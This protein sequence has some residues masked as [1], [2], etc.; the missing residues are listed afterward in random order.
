MI[1]FPH[2]KI[3]LGLNVTRRR[4]DGFHDIETVLY[5]VNWCDALEVIESSGG[6]PFTLDITGLPVSGAT[7]DNIIYKAWQKMSV[8]AKLPRMQVHLRKQ[9][10]MGAGLG[11][12]S[13]D[14]AFFL[15]LLNEKFELGLSDERLGAIAASLGSDC[16]FFLQAKP[17]LATGRGE[18][19]SPVKVDLGGYYIAVVYPA[20]HSNTA[21]AYKAI[22]PSGKPGLLAEILARPPETWRPTLRND[23][24]AVIERKFPVITEVVQQLYKDGA[25]YA[26]MSGSGSAVFGIFSQKPELQFPDNFLLHVQAPAK[27]L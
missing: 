17:M 3:N 12:G 27:I 11:G 1:C 10:P 14:A 7:T 15:K 26:A 21:E 13:A 25:L 16:S 18:V 2:C 24:E 5:S 4:E 20:V 19:L 8:I 23:F 6:M 9:I 22:A